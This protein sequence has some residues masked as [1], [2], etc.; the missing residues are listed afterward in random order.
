MT[1]SYINH[2]VIVQQ[3]IPVVR[4]AYSR[5]GIQVEFVEQ[6]SKRNLRLA[7]HGITD[8]ETAYS[9]L[10]VSSYPN[11]MLIG[12]EFF[13]SIFVLVCHI[14]EPCSENV[15]FDPSKIIVLTDASRDGLEAIYAE[16]LV[17]NMYSINS[18]KR[19]PLMI[20]GRR[21]R[22]GIYVTT[23]NDTSL[24]KFPDL[25]KVELFRTKT[26]HVLNDKFSALAPRVAKALQQVINE[27]DGDNP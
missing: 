17:S 27:S 13:E 25:N 26:H 19:I 15:L 1:F 3:V 2:P 8:G 21:L 7:S 24:D 20:D 6:P 14:T 10:L 4:S 16:K 12:P 23:E 9:D 22:Y 11:L 18:L 5:L